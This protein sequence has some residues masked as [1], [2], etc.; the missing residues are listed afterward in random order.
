MVT[1]ILYL[2]ITLI[3]TCCSYIILK[4]FLT[5]EMS[6][7]HIRNNL[8]REMKF[9]LQNKL[10]NI[11][12]QM[13]GENASIIPPHTFNDLHVNN[14]T[15]PTNNFSNYIDRID[16]LTYTLREHLN[17]EFHLHVDSRLYGKEFSPTF[18][19]FAYRLYRYVLLNMIKYEGLKMLEVNILLQ[20][21]Q[22]FISFDYTCPD[23]IS[24]T[25]RRIFKSSIQLDAEIE[26]RSDGI[27]FLIPIN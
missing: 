14:W 11:E 5:N 2:I 27:S 3:V 25:D 26:E 17:I 13:I 12:G 15:Y 1:L 8:T 9:E 22:L 18:Y 19:P 23:Q 20:E 10:T 24:F 4:Q 16:E 21:Q 7:N 6:L